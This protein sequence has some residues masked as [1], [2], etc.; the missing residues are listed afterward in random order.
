VLVSCWSSKGGA[1]VT[2]VAAGLAVALARTR[3]SALA[4]D[5]RG[6]LAPTLG[7]PEPRGPGVGEWLGAGTA[8][9]P[10][11]LARMEVEVVPGLG[12][13]HRGKGPADHG[14]AAVL[15]QL[16]ASSGRPTVVDCGRMDPGAPVD[17]VARAL[18][19]EADRSLLVTRLDYVSVRRA[20]DSGVRPSGIVVVNESWRC[21]SAADAARAI[22]A[23]VVAEI[24]LDPAVGRAVDSGQLASRLPKRFALAL[25]RVA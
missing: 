7:V 3:G 11:A 12:L 10:D 24:D 17:P 13:L 21:L 25:E 14:R 2:V 6:D 20:V 9:P 16:L 23:R 4:V 8:V 1:G 19:D 22:G 18:A 15:A 5:A